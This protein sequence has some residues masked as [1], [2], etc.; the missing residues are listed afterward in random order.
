VPGSGRYVGE[1]LILTI[2][3]TV[4]VALWGARGAQTET[5]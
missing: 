2:L 3:F 4:L 1:M 5:R